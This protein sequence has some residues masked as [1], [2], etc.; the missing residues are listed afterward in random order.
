ML[1]IY[2]VKE[3]GERKR[4]AIVRA[5]SSSDTA[6]LVAAAIGLTSHQLR[7]VALFSIIEVNFGESFLN[8]GERGVIAVF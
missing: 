8:G 5:H 6:D 7:D 1:G 3:R 2:H 4:E